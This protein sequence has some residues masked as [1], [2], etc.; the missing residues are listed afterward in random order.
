[1]GDQR[2]LGSKTVNKNKVRSYQD[3]ETDQEEGGDN[4]LHKGTLKISVFNASTEEEG[5]WV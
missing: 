5:N 4:I 3:G 2:G 1:M